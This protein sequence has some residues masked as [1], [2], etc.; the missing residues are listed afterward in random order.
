MIQVDRHRDFV[1]ASLAEAET[2]VVSCDRGCEFRKMEA[3]RRFAAGVA[4][5]F[6]NLLTI[7]GG[8]T[9]VILELEGLHA[10]GRR[11]AQG[12]KRAAERTCAVTRQLSNFSRNDLDEAM[13]VNPADLVMG[14][15]PLLRRLLGEDI[16]L[17]TIVSMEGTVAYV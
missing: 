5:D 13:F 7:I 3:L 10:T 4:H 16:A 8:Y 12:I 6:N 14:L 9:D 11:S 15:A 17:A 2:S 1:D